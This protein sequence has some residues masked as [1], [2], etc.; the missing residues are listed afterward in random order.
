MNPYTPPA[1]V[2]TDRLLLR[3]FESS[4]FDDLASIY[5]REDVVR[6]LYEPRYTD[7]DVQRA[8]EKRIGNRSIRG[9]GD[10]ISFAMVQRGGGALIGDCVVWVLSEQHSQGEIGFVVHPDHH[11]H[12]FATEAAREL[13]RIAFEELGLHRVV[14]NVEARNIS[15]A[16]VLEKLGMRPEA[17]LIENEFVKEEW[18][19][20]IIYAMLHREWQ[21]L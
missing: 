12:G 15:S 17:H 10:A 21:H 11:G 20:E 4:D 2:Q 6:F 13:L 7:T 18:Q 8:L 9:D 3:A 1:A 14:G 19:S 5:G 16:R